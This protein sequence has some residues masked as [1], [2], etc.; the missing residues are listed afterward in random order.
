MERM[1]ESLLMNIVTCNVQRMTMRE[2]NK[3]RVRSVCERVQKE[4]W[5]GVLLSELK[6][7]KS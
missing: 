5:M 2:H 6:A 7:D 1:E 4:E 3:K